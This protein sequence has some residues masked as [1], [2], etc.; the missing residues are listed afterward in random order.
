[1][2]RIRV[3]I[4]IMSDKAYAGKREDLTGP[5]LLAF[6]KEAEKAGRGAYDL[7]APEILPDE[8][9]MIKTRLRGLCDEGKADLILTSG[10][11]GLSPRDR[12]PEATLAVAEREVPGLAEGMRLASLKV[13]PMAMLSRAAAVLRKKTLILN[14]PGSPKAA[15]ENLDAVLDVLPHACEVLQGEASECANDEKVKKF[16]RS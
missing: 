7:S 15:K 1:M 5:A 6:L 11:T 16:S 2:E 12:T 10:G 3:K 14:L 4:L 9:E 8:E 13:T